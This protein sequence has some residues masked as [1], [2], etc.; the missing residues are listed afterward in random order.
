MRLKYEVQLWVLHFLKLVPGQIGCAVRRWAL[1]C[2]MSE[3]ALIWEDVH[4]FS[5]S[6]LELGRNVSINRGSVIHA[7][8]GVR[9]GDNSAIGPGVIIYS[10]NHVFRRNDIPFIEQG[11]DL[12]PVTI[13][14][15]TWVASRVIVLP[16]VTIGDDCVIAAGAVVTADVP[17]GVMVG[18]VPAR[19]IRQIFPRKRGE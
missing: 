1:P 19:V 15:N 3:G 7:G 11:Y 17:S 8:G 14:S 16:G 6:R 10:Q 2:K 5:P 4:I 13:G 18:G 9:V 12:A